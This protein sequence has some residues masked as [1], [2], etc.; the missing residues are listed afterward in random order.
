MKKIIVIALVALIATSSLFAGVSFSGRFRQGYTFA[1]T[2]GE[3]PSVSPWKTSEAKL[4]VKFSDD[5]GVWSVKLKT[6]GTKYD[7]NDQFGANATVDLTKALELAGVDTGDFSLAFSFGHNSKMT[8]LSAYADPN[9]SEYYKLKNNGTESFQV[10][11]GY[12]KLAQVN[13][14]FDPTTENGSVVV[15]AKSEPISGLAVAGAYA[16][17][18]YYDDAVTGSSVTAKN[19]AGFSVDVNIA[20][21]ASLDF[22]LGVTAFDNIAFADSTLNSFAAGVYG[23][24]DLVNG[25]VEFVMNN[26]EDASVFGLNTCVAFDVV[27]N[28]GLD[29]YFCIGDFANTST[30]FN[31]GGDISYTLAGVQF[32]L[33]ADYAAADKTFSLTPKMIIV[34]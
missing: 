20:E 18:G 19:M 6:V 17:N 22:D 13:L 16:Y 14:A 21:L 31:V 15:S 4:S 33:N 7:T 27:E 29:A 24:I 23:G 11:T 34:F 8:A 3:D 9:G 5:N 2:E 28:L 1:F 10:S 30:S 26:S 32:A 25:Y 12:G